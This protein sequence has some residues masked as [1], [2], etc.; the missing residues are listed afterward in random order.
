[1]S[2]ESAFGGERK[3]LGFLQEI[4][5]PQSEVNA[6]NIS[7]INLAGENAVRAIIADKVRK[8]FPNA[9]FSQQDI[10]TE[11]GPKVFIFD[12]LMLE[13][14]NIA[15]QIR[16]PTN[17][18]SS[19]QSL[20]PID[21]MFARIG[22]TVYTGPKHTDSDLKHNSY[23]HVGGGNFTPKATIDDQGSCLIA[24]NQAALLDNLG[25]TQEAALAGR[26]ARAEKA[27]ELGVKA[28]GE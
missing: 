5:K 3:G 28:P 17:N 10:P 4:L 8:V 26:E 22:F 13:G 27:T 19:R 18:E 24:V 11:T 1:M 23:A 7:Q 16:C 15:F 20:P 25:I 2:W 9:L 12:T 21:D 6:E 14:D